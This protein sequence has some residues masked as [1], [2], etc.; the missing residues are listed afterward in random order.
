MNLAVVPSAKS[1]L[2]SSN[3]WLARPRQARPRH[4]LHPTLLRALQGVP[5]G[6]VVRALLPEHSSPATHG[7]AV[8]LKTGAEFL[9]GYTCQIKQVNWHAKHVPI[10]GLVPIAATKWYPRRP[11]A[12]DLRPTRSAA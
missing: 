5:S 10:R 3:A 6:V 7:A 2:P 8:L 1:G 11:L 4:I 12:A 9:I